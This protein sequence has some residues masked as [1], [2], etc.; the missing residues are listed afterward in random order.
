M[1]IFLTPEAGELKSIS[2]FN[3]AGEKVWE[4][5]N[6]PGVSA[7]DITEWDGHNLHGQ[8]VSSGAYV[9]FVKTDRL[10]ARVKLLKIK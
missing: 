2:I 8:T 6:M 5:V 3:S 10:E 1:R 7:D 4:K 9:A